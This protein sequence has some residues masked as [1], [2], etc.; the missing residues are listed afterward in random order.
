MEA[1]LTENH[2]S[3]SQKYLE[4]AISLSYTYFKG[5]ANRP[6]VQQSS[7]SL[8]LSHVHPPRFHRIFCVPAV[9]KQHERVLVSRDRWAESYQSFL[10]DVMPCTERSPVAVSPRTSPL[11]DPHLM[12]SSH[13]VRSCRLPTT[14]PDHPKVRNGLSCCLHGPRISSTAP[15]I[16]KRPSPRTPRS[17]T[18]SQTQLLHIRAISSLGNS[19]DGSL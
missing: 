8:P 7:E 19:E 12:I 9:L 15:C 2:S 11:S 17:S 13:N 16:G 18:C 1:S 10:K 3:V 6:P 4:G 14:A 5:R